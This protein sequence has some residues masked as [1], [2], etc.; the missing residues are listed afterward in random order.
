MK[1]KGKVALLFQTCM[2]LMK[3]FFNIFK[4]F[5]LVDGFSRKTL[6]ITTDTTL[7]LIM[8]AFVYIF[9]C[10]IVISFPV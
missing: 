9:S 2:A 8:P 5:L 10:K 7:V 3:Y 4:I 6:T 1:Q